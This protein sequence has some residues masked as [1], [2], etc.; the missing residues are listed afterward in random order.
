MERNADV[1]PAGHETHL[2][3]I[4]DAAIMTAPYVG[5]LIEQR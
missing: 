2:L 1:D 3:G 5:A 4:G